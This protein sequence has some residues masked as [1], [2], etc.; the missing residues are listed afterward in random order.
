MKRLLFTVAAALAVLTVASSAQAQ[1]TDAQNF[2]VTIP[3]VFTLTAPADVTIVHDTSN[4]D[5]AFPTQAW[6]ARTNAINGATVS[7]STN[8]AFT[9]TVDNT[10]KRDAQL[11]LALF[12][13]ATSTVANWSVTTANDVTNYVGLDETATVQAT[14]TRPGRAQFDLLVTFLMGGADFA[15]LAQGDYTLTVTGTMTANP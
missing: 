14:S 10:F 13:A 1:V 8:Q 15:D 9:H 7:F 11:D 6:I 2:T 3:Q 12:P 4:A 5:Q